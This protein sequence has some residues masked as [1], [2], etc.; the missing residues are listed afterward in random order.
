MTSYSRLFQQN[1]AL[2][3]KAFPVWSKYIPHAPT[4]KQLAFLMLPNREA[5][6]GGAAGGGK[7][8]A[9]LM[10][11]LQFVE[12][13][14]YSAIVFRK[15]LSDLQLEGAL[16]QRSHEWL[17]KTDAHWNGQ[18]HKWTFPSGAVIQFGYLAS[19]LVKYRYQGA[20]FQ[21]I[22]FDELTQFPEQ[23]YTYLFSRNRR[24]KCP[25]HYPN[26][27]GKC[28]GC[29]ESYYQS[30]VPLR[31]R[32]ASN[33]GGLGH[34][35]VR[36]R[37]NIQQTS[38]RDEAGREHVMYRG[39]H[40]KR[41][42]V[43][44]FLS[45]NPYLDQ[46]EYQ[47]SLSELDPVTREQLLR[48]DWAVSADGRFRKKWMRYYSRNGDYIVLGPDRRGPTIHPNRCRCFVTVDPAASAREGPGDADIYRDRMPSWTVISVWWLTPDW[49]LIWRDCIRFQVEIPEIFPA[50]KDA[51][52]K[53]QPEFMGIEAN[54]LNIGVFQGAQRLGLPIKP[55]QPRSMDKLV[56]ATDAANRMEQGKIWLPQDRL[57]N[58]WVDDVEAELFTWVGHPRE[59]AD[60]VD[61]LAYAAMEVSKE[62][63][64]SEV[65]IHERDIP[66]AW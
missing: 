26:Y 1:P 58:P 33:P 47:E 61:T 9:L 36:S 2:A 28:N 42:H 54:G 5:F 45:D 53:Y 60:I 49:H 14:G 11:A 27:D 48:G 13:P 38:W 41:P 32:S 20:E 18:L 46:E 25:T 62:S 23:D 50:L 39:C 63:A 65:T 64:F 52:A 66:G 55:L 31:V 57:N 43:P 4:P 3:E 21:Y 22:A 29:K 35:W 12:Y 44:A 19:E 7:S 8:D 16:I 15:T 6:Y 17:G 37:F 40:P 56:R 24:K 51:Y 59:Q 34:L 10:G 30:Q